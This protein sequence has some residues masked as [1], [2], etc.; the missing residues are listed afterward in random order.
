MEQWSVGMVEW[1][2]GGVSRLRAHSEDVR[3]GF[4]RE[5]LHAV[6][7]ERSRQDAIH[8]IFERALA[9]VDVSLGPQ[10]T[11]VRGVLGLRCQR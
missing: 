11:Q 8:T 6:I 3:Y 7:I 2:N 5:N 9:R 10:L 4:S 1:W